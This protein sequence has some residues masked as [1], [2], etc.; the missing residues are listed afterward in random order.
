MVGGGSIGQQE[1]ACTEGI[2][3]FKE[4]SKLI[5]SEGMKKAEAKNLSRAR[6]FP[7][8]RKGGG[9]LC[10]KFCGNLCQMNQMQ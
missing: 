2:S 6:L 7:G 1:D 4:V 8:R 10:V 5:A 9:N 3:I